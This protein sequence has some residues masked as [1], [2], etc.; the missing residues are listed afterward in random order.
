MPF[1]TFNSIMMGIPGL[2]LKIIIFFI[3]STILLGAFLV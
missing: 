3:I 2:A 1:V